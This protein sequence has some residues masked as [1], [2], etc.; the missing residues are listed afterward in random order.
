LESCVITKDET[1][2]D[3]VTFASVENDELGNYITPGYPELGV[4]Y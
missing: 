1:A 3:D 4:E 2:I